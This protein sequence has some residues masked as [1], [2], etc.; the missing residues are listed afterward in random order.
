MSELIGLAGERVDEERSVGGGDNGEG[1]QVK[2]KRLDSGT[3]VHVESNE[4]IEWKE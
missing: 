4:L 1:G 3:G 2:G